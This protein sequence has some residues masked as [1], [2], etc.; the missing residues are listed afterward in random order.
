MVGEAH[1]IGI[2]EETNTGDD[3]STDVIPS[4]RCLV[5]F[6]EGET[7]A[8]IGVLNMG[9]VIVEVVEGG[10]STGGLDYRSSFHCDSWARYKE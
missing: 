4:E 3:T 8:F 10:I 5:D 7:T 2:R 1:I 9:K 6:G